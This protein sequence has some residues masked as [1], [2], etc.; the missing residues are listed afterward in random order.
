MIKKVEK[1]KLEA[2]DPKTKKFYNKFKN[3]ILKN[4]KKED[5]AVAVSGG[6]DSMCLAYFGKIYESEFKNKMHVLIVD[7]KLRIESR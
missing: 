5:F 2:K 1:K 7:H 4:I 6:P 3:I